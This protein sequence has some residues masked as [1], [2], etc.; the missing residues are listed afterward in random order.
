MDDDEFD[1]FSTQLAAFDRDIANK[2]HGKERSENENQAGSSNHVEVNNWSDDGFGDL[3][4]EQYAVLDRTIGE[5]SEQ[6]EPNEINN[7]NVNGNGN[8]ESVITASQLELASAIFDD[9]ANEPSLEHLECLRSK[10]NLRQ[11]RDKQWEIIDLVMNKKRD[12]NAVMATGYGKSLCFQFPAVFKNG[13]I[14]VICPLKSLMQAQVMTLTE[15]K[16]KACYVGSAQSDKQIYSRIENGEFN[17]IYSSPELIQTS[18]GK[19]MLDS[20]VGRLMLI[21]IDGELIN[22]IVIVSCQ[23]MTLLLC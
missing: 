16:I 10:F 17:I 4:E 21:A 23:P 20:L 7:N 14:L 19:R 12:V 3:T 22:R 8:Q 6:Q 1:D 13:M 2:T 9:D 11:F 15:A 5:N 18:N